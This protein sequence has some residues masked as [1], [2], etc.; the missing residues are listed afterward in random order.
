MN[1]ALCFAL[2]FSSLV[3]AEKPKL[4][5]LDLTPGGGADPQVVAAFTE[6]LTATISKAGYFDV[7]SS[8]DVA[9]LLGV[10]RQKQ[11]LGCSDGSCMAELS[12][13]I[14][15]RFILSGSLVKLGDSWQLTMTTLDTE[16]SQPVGRAVRI[17]SQLTA[18]HGAAAVVER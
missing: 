2:L 18:L 1:R 16:R 15:A 4:V 7:A 13:A 10:E 17:A 3:W 12:G 11:L 5:V 8:R 9:Q 6:A 14:G